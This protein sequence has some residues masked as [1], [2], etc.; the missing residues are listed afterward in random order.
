MAKGK[1]VNVEKTANLWKPAPMRLQAR[2]GNDFLAQRKRPKLGQ[3]FLADQHAAQRIV[4]A[5]G[6]VSEKTVIEIG[7]GRGVL[8]A[9]LAER[10]RRLIAIEL[11][12]VLAAQ[13]RMSL[14][15]FENVEIIEGDI[16]SI[17]FSTVLGPRPG[18]NHPG[19]VHVPEKTRLVGNLPYFI[20]SDILLRLFQYHPYFETIVIMVQEEV[21]DRIAAKPGVRDY[22]LLSATVQLY[23]RVEKLFSL[24][25][26]AFNPPPKVHSAVLRLT[27]N[28][29]MDRLRVPEEEFIAFLKLSFGQKRKTLANNLK[30]RFDSRLLSAA[31]KKAGLQ[32]GVRA[33]AVSL[34]KMAAVFRSLTAAAA[35]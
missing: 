5:L 6:Q 4:D 28:P 8:T 18:M 13:L 2:V 22:G 11:D 15:R 10:A 7:P 30:S 31:L 34:E 9:M 29:Q 17:D 1:R 25:P 12:R 20:T 21:A 19:I 23:A 16:L 27:I 3:H 35:D 33:E 24:P 14:V 32:P 26:G